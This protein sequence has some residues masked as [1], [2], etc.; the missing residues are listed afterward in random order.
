MADNSF[1]TTV[2]SLFKGMDSFITTKTVVG[3][4]IHIGETIILPLVDV[5]FGVAAGAFTQ[6]KKN[7]GAGG[8]GGKIMPS[9]VL[10]IQNGTTKLVNIKN[11]DGVTKILDMVPDFVNKFTASKNNIVDE[12]AEDTDAKQAAEKEMEEILKDSVNKEA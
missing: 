7:N 12:P 1:N 4:A 3:D 5:S 10:V 2:E 11:Q 8:M 6:E 9:A